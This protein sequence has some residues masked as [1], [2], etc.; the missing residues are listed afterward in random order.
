MNPAGACK[1]ESIYAQRFKAL[2]AMTDLSVREAE[3]LA[4]TRRGSLQ[5]IH[6]GSTRSPGLGL[7]N[8]LADLFGVTTDYLG[9]RTD[10]DPALE[11]VLGSVNRAR[12]TLAPEPRR[13]RQPR[14]SASRA[15][16]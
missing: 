12:S 8:C 14:R 2:L 13:W 15:T 10:E 3:R 7:L 4:A 11:H 16:A 5:A 1:S 9:G 6:D